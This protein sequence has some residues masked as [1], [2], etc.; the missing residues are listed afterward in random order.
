[1]GLV[2][3]LERDGQYLTPTAV[4]KIYHIVRECLPDRRAEGTQRELGA[5]IRERMERD[6]HEPR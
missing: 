6:D 4:G 2:R 5:L 1:M 3:M